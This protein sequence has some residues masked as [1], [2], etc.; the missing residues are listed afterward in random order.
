M[1]ALDASVIIAH[2]NRA[3]PHHEA[4]TQTLLDATPG[5]MLVHTVTLAEVLVGGVRIGQGA[6]MQNDLHAAG[7]VLAPYHDDEPLRLAELRVSTGLRLPDCC[8]LGVAI[9]HRASLATFDSTLA[10]VAHRNGVALAR[11]CQSAGD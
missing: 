1:I 11:H 8:V 4:A 6:S 10:D 5:R 3:D 7:I 9:H 2:L